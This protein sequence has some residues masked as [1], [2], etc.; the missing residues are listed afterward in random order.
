MDFS[1]NTVFCGL[2]TV[3]FVPPAAGDY[4]FDGK[5]TLPSQS[6]GDSPSSLIVTINKNA[7]PVYTGQ[8]G[9]R[10]FEQVLQALLTSDS[11]TIVF[12]SAAAADQPRN[13]IKSCISI[14]AGN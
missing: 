14:S 2:G 3:T 6:A 9:A 8:A 10:G 1:Q 12:S 4:K 11:I 5:I 13:V 7:S